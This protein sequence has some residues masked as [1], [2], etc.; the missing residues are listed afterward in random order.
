MLWYLLIINELDCDLLQD[1]VMLNMS[2]Y[3]FSDVVKGN[4][5]MRSCFEMVW[6]HHQLLQ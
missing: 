4:D 6:D 5:K 3:E 2:R 1:I